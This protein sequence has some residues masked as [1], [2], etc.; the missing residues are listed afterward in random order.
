MKPS[1]VQPT[2]E[3]E[4]EREES[5]DIMI[6][7]VWVI[8]LLTSSRERQTAMEPRRRF[9]DLLNDVLSSLREA[10]TAVRQHNVIKLLYGYKLGGKFVLGGDS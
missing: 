6:A 8:E 1:A 9:S 7:S 3:R 10:I 5:G 4:R 2:T